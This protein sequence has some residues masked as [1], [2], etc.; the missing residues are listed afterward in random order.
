MSL[1]KQGPV[2]KVGPK[3]IAATPS[4]AVLFLAA[5][6]LVFTPLCLIPDRNG[7]TGWFAL[8]L[9]LP[10]GLWAL[11]YSL[12]TTVI[13]D[14][15][16]LRWRKALGPWQS[17]AWDDVTDYFRLVDK[18]L[19]SRTVIVFRD[20]RKLSLGSDWND[21]KRLEAWVVEHARAAK[22]KGWLIHGKEGTLQGSHTFAYSP[23][24]VRSQKGVMIVFALMALLM[25]LGLPLAAVWADQSKGK[26]IGLE[27][28]LLFGFSALFWLG[29]LV[30]VLV[31]TR[32]S[33]RDHQERLAHG[34]RFEAD[35]QGFTFWRDGEPHQVAWSALVSHELAAR[36]TTTNTYL[37]R[38]QTGQ[39]EFAYTSALSEGEKFRELIALYAPQVARLV[40]RAPSHDALAS[41]EWESGRRTFHYRTRSNRSGLGMLWIVPLFCL[42]A[43]GGLVAMWVR[44]GL[45]LR[46]LPRDNLWIIFGLALV[47]VVVWGFLL[48]RYK[49]ARLVLDRESLTA[50]GLWGARRVFFEELAAVGRDDLSLYVE[51]HDGK[52]PIRWGA[53]LAGNTKLLDEL[54]RRAGVRLP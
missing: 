33:L 13:A 7:Q 35:E 16:G 46:E 48:W 51:T 2:Q 44:Y 37:H 3:R 19:G 4:R 6:C 14:A 12:R 27:M 43:L 8:P 20:G 49:N 15:D 21:L 23:Q 53:N 5:F 36:N 39:Q 1:Q 22:A 47:A 32:R 18:N 38:L 30:G 10:G 45:D 26:E 40:H 24:F 52:R 42:L 31:Q 28:L 54:E 11:L 50:Y 41:T 29:M 9:L 34:E 17:A 25:G